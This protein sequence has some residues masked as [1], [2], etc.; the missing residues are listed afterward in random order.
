MQSI[1]IVLSPGE[2]INISPIFICGGPLHHVIYH[3]AISTSDAFVF[4]FDMYNHL[5]MNKMSS[6]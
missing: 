5:Y 2:S 6:L 3:V 4:E 1:T